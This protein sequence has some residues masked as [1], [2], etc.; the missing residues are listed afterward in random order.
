MRHMSPTALPLPAVDLENAYFERVA[1][2]GADLPF[3][4][5]G[6][7]PD[8]FTVR[9]ATQTTHV[10]TTSRSDL[11]GESQSESR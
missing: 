1:P 3:L 9:R 11:E 4:V 2:L 6:A 7:G 10:L 8:S 5:Y